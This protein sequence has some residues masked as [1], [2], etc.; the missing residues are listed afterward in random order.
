MSPADR[1]GRRPLLSRA[2]LF[3]S[4]PR[5][6]VQPVASAAVDG[7]DLGATAAVKETA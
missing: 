7:V 4:G 1:T 2:Q 3:H 6:G 5:R